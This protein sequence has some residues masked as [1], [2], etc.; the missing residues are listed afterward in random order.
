ML[1]M[2]GIGLMAKEAAIRTSRP[3]TT[4]SAAIMLCVFE[5]GRH[6]QQN[7]GRDVEGDEAAAEAARQGAF[8]FIEFPER[9]FSVPLTA[10]G[11]SLNETC[12]G[13]IAGE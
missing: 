3:M 2:D 13:P 9:H 7:D 4:S 11:L 8:A 5:K 6:D 10:S 12:S 1:A